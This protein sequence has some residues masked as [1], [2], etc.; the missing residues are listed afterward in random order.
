MLES[1]RFAFT[2]RGEEHWQKSYDKLKEYREEHGHV[3]VPRQC[4]IPGLG[5]WVSVC[6]QMSDSNVERCCDYVR[7]VVLTVGDIPF[8]VYIASSSRLQASVSNT[9][10]TRKASQPPLRS[11]A[12]I[13]SMK[14]AFSGGFATV[15]SGRLSLKSC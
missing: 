11:S 15:P 12:K 6:L 13:C 10:T 3:L 14:L 8:V 9:R 4:E 7:N 5:D 1:V 2:T